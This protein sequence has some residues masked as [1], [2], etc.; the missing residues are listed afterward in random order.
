[1]AKKIAIPSAQPG[2]VEAALGMHFGHCDCYTLVD[3]DDN[4]EITAV[5]TIPCV[6]H[7]QGGCLAP[8]MYLAEQGVTD[9]LAGGMGMRPLMGFLQNNIQVFWAANHATVGDAVV[10]FLAN[11]LPAFTPANTCRG[12]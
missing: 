11:K 1:M 7:A 5:S 4:G 6:S 3:I 2:G 12:H 8:V 10:A 9:L